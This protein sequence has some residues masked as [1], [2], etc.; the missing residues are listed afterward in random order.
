[1]RSDVTAPT[2]TYSRARSVT[3][4][5]YAVGKT[6][7]DML[8][9]TAGTGTEVDQYIT[10]CTQTHD[11]ATLRMSFP[12]TY[13]LPVANQCISFADNGVT[14]FQGVI[15]FVSDP[16]ELRGSDYTVDVVVRRRDA[17]PAWREV[18]RVSARYTVGAELGAIAR[19]CATDSALVQSDEMSIGRLGITLAHDETQFVDIA[20]WDMLK[21]V[22]AP[23]GYEPFINALGL[24]TFISRDVRRPS[25]YTLADS[26]QLKDVVPARSTS[27]IS[28]VRVRYTDPFLVLVEQ[29]SR[30][31][32]SE[33]ITCGFFGQVVKNIY[34]SDDQKMR[35][36]NVWFNRKQS[37]N[38]NAGILGVVDAKITDDEYLDVEGARYGLVAGTNQ[39]EISPRI[40][41]GGILYILP[42]VRNTVSRLFNP[43]DPLEGISTNL[44]IDL[45]SLSVSVYNPIATLVYKIL[46]LASAVQVIGTGMYEVY[47]Q[48]VDWVHATQEVEVYDINAAASAERIEVIE[49]GLVPNEEV[50]RTLAAIELLYRSK[51]ASKISLVIA[52]DPR[53]E[54]G[55]IFSLPNGRRVYATGY[56]RDLARGS[57]ALLTVE[58][59]YV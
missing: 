35:A 31:L 24:L 10:Q 55:D 11:G 59:F 50:A 22:G 56:S 37:V 40:S 1:M 7:R 54:P 36:K 43:T 5:L 26:V 6:P 33:T 8:V 51:S 47:G 58:G 18:K 32:W 38:Q 23:A 19:K 44:G 27:P 16:H 42:D 15:E 45:D 52:D 39:V 25:T 3:A 46:E 34:W 30:V 2:G 14:L 57:E 28:A 13:T 17:V 48:P 9:G 12:R 29:Q 20:L 53:V 41:T 21:T 4:T 49:S